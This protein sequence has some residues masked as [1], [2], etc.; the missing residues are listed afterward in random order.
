MKVI[1]QQGSGNPE[2]LQNLATISQWWENLKNQEISWKQRIFSQNS[3]VEQL[4]WEQ[5]RFDEVFLIANPEIRGIT[6]Y[7][8]KPDSP[9]VRNT[10]PSQIILDSLHQYLYIFPQ[11]QKELVIRVGLPSIPY[12][13]ITLTN[14]QYEYKASDNQHTLI[15]RDAIQQIEVKVNLNVDN[16]KELLRQLTR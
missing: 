4:D 2:N 7:W 3:E 5:K 1:W 9:Q 8:Q 16:L 13:K 11:S 10:T 12:Q 14:P 15:L 6:L